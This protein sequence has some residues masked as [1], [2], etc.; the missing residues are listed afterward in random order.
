[1]RNSIPLFKMRWYF[2]YGLS[3][4]KLFKINRYYF[5]ISK[6]TYKKHT[7]FVIVNSTIVHFSRFLDDIYN[8]IF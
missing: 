5:I 4:F 3:R 2:E 7:L 8:L 6:I 1:M